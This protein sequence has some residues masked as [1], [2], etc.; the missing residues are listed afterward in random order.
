MI[1]DAGLQVLSS[2]F[3]NDLTNI[4]SLDLSYNNINPLSMEHILKMLMNN[5]SIKR[6]MLQNNNLQERG[7]KLLVTSLKDHKKI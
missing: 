6:L 1:S 5:N 2:N 7:T 3:G 4:K